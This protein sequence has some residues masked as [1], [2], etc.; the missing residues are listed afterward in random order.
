M[1]L[2]DHIIRRL[3]HIIAAS[4]SDVDLTMAR[5]EKNH[6]EMVLRLVC[7]DLLVAS[8]VLGMSRRSLERKGYR[9][10]VNRKKKG[11]KHDR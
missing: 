11:A 10:F 7:G 3:P 1:A 8:R 9:S 5:V 6:I 4:L 2:G